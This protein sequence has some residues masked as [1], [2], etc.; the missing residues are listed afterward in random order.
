MG[1]PGGGNVIAGN[2]LGTVN[3]ANVILYYSSGSVVQ[4]NFI[5]TDITGTVALSTTTYYGVVL[6]LGSYIIGGLTPTPGT[7]LG[8]VISGNSVAAF[9]WLIT[10]RRCHDRHRR[11]HHRRRCDRQHAVPNAMTASIS[12]DVSRVTIGGTAAGAGNLISG[13]TDDRRRY[14]RRLDGDRITWSRAT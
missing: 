1:E 12:T 5:G 9:S 14:H 8:N 7:G 10:R 6:E 13:N 2:G 11:Q 3:G 4:S